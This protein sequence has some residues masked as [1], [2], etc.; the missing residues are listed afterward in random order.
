MTNIEIISLLNIEV[1]KIMSWPRDFLSLC[2]IADELNLEPG[3]VYWNLFSNDKISFS[4]LL[5]K[6]K[7]P[8]RRTECVMF[9]LGSY[10]PCYMKSISKPKDKNTNDK[11][12]KGRSKGKPFSLYKVVNGHGTWILTSEEIIKAFSRK[13]LVSDVMPAVANK[14]Q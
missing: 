13:D 2:E 9:E 6:G 10:K 8:E 1:P 4:G 7:P 14:K 3:M 11:E 5:S 12:D